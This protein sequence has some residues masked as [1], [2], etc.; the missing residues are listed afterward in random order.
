M[1]KAIEATKMAGGS[2]QATVCYSISPVH[3]VEHYA[4][5]A[6]SLQKAGS[7]LSCPRI[8]LGYLVPKMYEI[9][10][11][12]KDDVG[13]PVQIHCPTSGMA[14]MVY[15]ALAGA[16]VVDCAILLFSCLL[17]SRL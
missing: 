1:E 4:K 12:W 7:G 17:L 15:L 16:D 5:I 13:L 8:W 14:S 6:K 11:R 10:R 9:V 2:V 3:D